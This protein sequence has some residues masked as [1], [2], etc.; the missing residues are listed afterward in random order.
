MPEKRRAGL[1]Q[2]YAFLNLFQGLTYA[3]LLLFFFL[4]LREKDHAFR[5]LPALLLLGEF[6]FSVIWEAKS[7]YI[8][9]YILMILPCAAWSLTYYAGKV[10]EGMKKWRKSPP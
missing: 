6:C 10:A 7:R 5:F 8:Y 4:L 1:T 9:P 2:W 3:M